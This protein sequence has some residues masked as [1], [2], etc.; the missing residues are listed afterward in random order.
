MS[1]VSS[2]S[3]S[4]SFPTG[5]GSGSKIPEVNQLCL[6]RVAETLHDKESAVG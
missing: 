1:C 6:Q 5:N 4:K 3:S 2:L